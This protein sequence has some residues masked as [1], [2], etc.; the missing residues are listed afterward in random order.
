MV[1]PYQVCFI[2]NKCISDS[3]DVKPEISPRRPS[4]SILTPIRHKQNDV[5]NST[6]ID[7]VTEVRVKEEVHYLCIN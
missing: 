6:I 5:S 3:E 2:P 7:E 4:V 1:G